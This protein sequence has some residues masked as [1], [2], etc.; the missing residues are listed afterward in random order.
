MLLLLHIVLRLLQLP[1][2]SFHVNTM[3]LQLIKAF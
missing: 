1:Q 2:I 3:L